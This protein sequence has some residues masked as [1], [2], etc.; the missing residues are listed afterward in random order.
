MII[1]ILHLLTHSFQVMIPASS[2][3]PPEG[4]KEAGKEAKEVQEKAPTNNLAATFAAQVAKA[5]GETSSTSPAPAAGKEGVQEVK[6][7]E[8]KEEVKVVE[9]K[10]PEVVKEVE[11]KVEASLPAKESLSVSTELGNRDDPLYEPVSP[12]PL[13]DSPCDEAKP[14]QEKAALNRSLNVVDHMVE[15]QKTATKPSPFEEVINKK[16]GAVNVEKVEEGETA[17][18]GNN[19]AKPRKQS[20]AAKKA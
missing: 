12:T 13:P 19:K 2:V 3:T 14:G 5:A 1:F 4:G 16:A 17:K 7:K 10:V 18:H 6:I 11:V 9:E 20:A 8:A 15:Q